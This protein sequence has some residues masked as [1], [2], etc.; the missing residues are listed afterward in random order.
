MFSSPELVATLSRHVTR[1]VGHTDSSIMPHGAKSAISNTGKSTQQNHSGGEL[2]IE[3]KFGV[4]SRFRILIDEAASMP[5]DNES[6]D[7]SA[8]SPAKVE[9]K[10]KRKASKAE[11]SQPDK[12]VNNISNKPGK[13]LIDLSPNNNSENNPRSSNT[14]GS[15][16]E[17]PAYK[18]LIKGHSRQYCPLSLH[19]LKTT[20]REFLTYRQRAC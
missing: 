12:K 5:L 9:R 20:I 18:Y 2:S 1:E 17:P 19:K 10:Y 4:P 14:T 11:G 15:G 8:V 6:M 3:E 7:C 16:R 13:Q